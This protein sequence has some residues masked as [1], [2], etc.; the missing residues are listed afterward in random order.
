MIRSKKSDNRRIKTH[1]HNKTKE[2]KRKREKTYKG[3]EKTHPVTHASLKRPIRGDIQGLLYYLLY[4]G[5][6]MK[7]LQQ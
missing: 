1:T 6:K 7:E 5:M 3:N 2:R 4:E